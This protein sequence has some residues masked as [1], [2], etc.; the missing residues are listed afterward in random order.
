MFKIKE[1]VHISLI[2]TD[3]QT[4]RQTDRGTDRQRQRESNLVFYAQR[5]RETQDFWLEM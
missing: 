5:E 3:R 2:K 4:D 1:I